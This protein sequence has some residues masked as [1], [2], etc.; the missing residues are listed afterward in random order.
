MQRTFL[1]TL[2]LSMDLDDDSDLLNRKDYR[3]LREQMR[4]SDFIKSLTDEQEKLFEEYCE[5]ETQIECINQEIYYSR[6]FK[7]GLHAGL[8][9]ATPKEFV[10]NCGMCPAV[11][12]NDDD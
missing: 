9:C 10:Q 4:N 11:N 5:L 7:V 8:E 12:Q 6:G 3:R 2:Y 1:T